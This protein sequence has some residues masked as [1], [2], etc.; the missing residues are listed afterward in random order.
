MESLFSGNIRETSPKLRG[1]VGQ[2]ATTPW[3]SPAPALE[4]LPHS[5]LSV[6]RELHR[7]GNFGALDNF[8]YGCLFSAGEDMIVRNVKVHGP[9]CDAT[10]PV[11]CSWPVVSKR[12]AGKDYMMLVE[13]ATTDDCPFLHC[14]SIADW[15]AMS[16]VWESPLA[17]LQRHGA[18]EQGADEGLARIIGKPIPLLSFAARRAFYDLPKTTLLELGRRLGCDMDS[19]ESILQRVRR[20]VLHVLGLCCCISGGRGRS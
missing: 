2:S 6:C 17:R 16:I 7:I 13:R 1:I 20:L 9:L 11:K 19:G 3:F 8:F 10:H 14:Y 4:C 5:G 18:A 15:E 12:L